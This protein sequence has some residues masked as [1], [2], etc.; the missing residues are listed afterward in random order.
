MT[1]DFDKSSIKL[2]IERGIRKA[3][4][5]D[6]KGA[7]ED[8]NQV[9]S[10]NPNQGT[11]YAFRGA[12]R[13]ELREYSRAI[14]D[15]TQA[16]QLNPHH[17]AAYAYRGD[18]Q[19]EL[20]NYRKAIEDYTQAL[21][22]KPDFATVHRKRSSVRLQ[23]GDR[24]GAIDDLHKAASLLLEQGNVDGYQRTTDN[25]RKLQS[26][27]QQHSAAVY[28]SN[29]IAQMQQQLTNLQQLIATLSVPGSIQNK[30]E[31]LASQIQDMESVIV[32]IPNQLNE[33]L[34]KQVIQIN[35]LLQQM[36]S[37]HEYELYS[38]E[39]AAEPC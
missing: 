13:A 3:E 1:E 7:I 30:L 11:A 8:F 18:A 19:A 16:L 17:A 39:M 29:Q 22:L 12:A 36:P 27:V 20:T 32:G 14:E 21:R 38:I 23:L 26:E 10:I 9:L 5:G 31:K 2:L 25:I 15:L 33:T 35:Q 24:Q 37:S 28:D 6:Y 4:E 34:D